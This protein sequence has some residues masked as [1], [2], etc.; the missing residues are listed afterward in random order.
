METNE[1]N[2]DFCK[3]KLMSGGCDNFY[4]H[5]EC[6][7]APYENDSGFR[8]S[9]LVIPTIDSPLDFCGMG[10]LNKYMENK[11]ENQ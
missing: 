1:I 3:T 8:F 10:C 4:L 5:L 2:C 7:V 11:N 9:C 6:L